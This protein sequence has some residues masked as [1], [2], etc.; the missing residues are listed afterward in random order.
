MSRTERLPGALAMAFALILFACGGSASQDPQSLPISQASFA[1]RSH[2]K[3]AA[4]TVASE[5]AGSPAAS[6]VTTDQPRIEDLIL[7]S[8]ARVDRTR[9]DYK[10]RL[11]VRGAYETFSSGTFTVASVPSGSTATVGT[12]AF[13]QI[14]AQRLVPSTATITIRH[15]RTYP[16]V[17]AN[18]K[19]AFNGQPAAADPTPG[20]PRIGPVRYYSYG[21]RP[22]H[23]GYFESSASNPAAG[24]GTQLRAILSAGVSAANYSFKSMSGTV[25]S[26]GDIV[27]LWPNND[28]ASAMVEIPAEPFTT[29]IAA[30]GANGARTSWT[31][32]P[33]QP[34]II[35]TELIIDN[36]AFN[37]GDVIRGRLEIGKTTKADK[38][39]VEI[40]LPDGFSA[41]QTHLEIALNS[42]AGTSVPILIQTPPSGQSTRFHKIAIL[43]HW[44]SA[45]GAATALVASVFSR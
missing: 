43:H 31:S 10:F 25:L 39:V 18:L 2:A 1:T 7:V 35:P 20:T 9:F 32:S 29:T 21:G 40:T 34:R 8:S 17:K 22:G 42:A 23:E 24:P 27:K 33:V 41:A 14:D 15:D 3:A 26:T 6:N 30:T 28:E 38:L 4:A 44:A 16:F 13:G 11:L 12:V 36:G 19:F 37:F 5:S 45:P